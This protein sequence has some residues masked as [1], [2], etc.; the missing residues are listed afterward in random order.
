MTDE[1]ISFPGDADNRYHE[2]IALFEEACDAGLNPDP[3]EWL[4]HYP[5]VADRLAVYL[6]DRE[7]L[8]RLTE[9]ASA[10]EGGQNV[11]VPDDYLILQRIEAGGMGI[12]YK[13]WQRSAKRVVALKVIRP[14]RL[15]D[16]SPEQ[17]RRIV[18][19]F[20]I[21]AQSPAQ[22]EHDHIVSVYEVGEVNGQPFSDRVGSANPQTPT[23]CICS[24][25]PPW[26][27][28]SCGSARSPTAV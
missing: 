15:A 26:N 2:A 7:K 6:A 11:V 19:R 18:E 28:C 3:A 23:W 20:A 12:V 10:G 27:A 13:A 16:L 17:R 1:H 5:D 14:D 9:A 22:L 4:A 21:E 24:H 25:C 8:R